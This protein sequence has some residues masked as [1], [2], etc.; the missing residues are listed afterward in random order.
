MKS[1]VKSVESRGGARFRSKIGGLGPI[2]VARCRP[3]GTVLSLDERVAEIL[4]LERSGI[5][6]NAIE[7][8]NISELLTYSDPAPFIELGTGQRHCARQL[9][10][11]TL[12]GTGRWIMVGQ[13]SEQDAK[14]GE[15][16]VQLG[17]CDFSDIVRDWETL[18]LQ[19][20]FMADVI[21][22][23]SVPMFAV[24]EEHKVVLWN[25][26]C[27][28]LTGVKAE[29]VLGTREHWKAFHDR[30]QACLCDVIIDREYDS[31]PKL[32]ATSSRSSLV[33][34]GWQAEGWFTSVSGQRRYVLFDA[35]P[36][37]TEDG[38]LRG[39]VETVIDLTRRQGADDEF[40]RRQ[41]GFADSRK[42]EAVSRMASGIA[43]DFNNLLT[44]VLGYARLIRET[45]GPDD[46]I[47]ADAGE[48]LKA[49]E[50]AADL[51]KKLL[52]F[53]RRQILDMH[54]VNVNSVVLDL[55]PWLRQTLGETVEIKTMLDAEI[56]PVTANEQQLQQVIM[57]LGL[58]ARDAMPQGGTLVIQ[59]ERLVPGMQA[60][61]VQFEDVS[62][63]G[64]RVA[65]SIRDT[66]CGMSPEI[67]EHLFEPFFTTKEKGQG[68]GLG[69]STVY[70][71]VTQIHGHVRIE[72]E[73]DAG[74]KVTVL[75]PVS[76][77]SL[78][79]ADE[80]KK[81]MPLPGG[82]E[83]ILVVEDDDAIRHMAARLLKSLGY[84]VLE[85]ADGEAGLTLGKTYGEPIHL[86]VSD[87]VMP[88]LGGQL[89]VDGLRKLRSDF[90]VLYTSGYTDGAVLDHS[91]LSNHDSVMLK[92]YACDG[93]AMKIR[94]VLDHS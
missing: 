86:V 60:L 85:A 54:P 28:G 52:T 1:R 10:V 47:A 58:N 19:R 23:A 48:I 74:T 73:Q 26:A 38:Q 61:A 69:L 81:E 6:F 90:R 9:F 2:G 94:Q 76:R 17:I 75:L 53:S 4:E 51:T 46:P 12:S 3:D 93:L 30:E 50:R 63:H 71:I 21:Q 62:D 92:P 18:A 39:A 22:N 89:M 15:E 41:E 25:K 65:L 67:R 78:G 32:Y 87:I 13:F 70:G 24:N 43:H 45:V 66:G 49:G 59:T 79:A 83:T 64:E 5:N 72:S 27:E 14:T 57:N 29:S 34:Q 36:I 7:G 56:G 33:P 44:A 35:A 16:V 84:T 80:R 77:A 8:K 42:M 88:H 20:E 40:R 82:H 55:V 31:I 11:L 91:R 68:L 37:Y